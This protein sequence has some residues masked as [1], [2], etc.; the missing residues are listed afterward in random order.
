M[1]GTFCNAFPGKSGTN[2]VRVCI[3]RYNFRRKKFYFLFVINRLP[4][5]TVVK[6]ITNNVA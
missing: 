2:L 1:F 5:L 3:A 6:A 4:M